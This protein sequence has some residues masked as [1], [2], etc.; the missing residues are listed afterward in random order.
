MIDSPSAIRTISPCRSAKCSGAI[1][2]P[3][4]RDHRRAHVVDRKRHH[5][6]RDPRVPLDEGGHHEQ[7]RR[8]AVRG[9]HYPQERAAGRGRCEQRWRRGRGGAR[10]RRG[11]RTRTRR[12]VSE[13]AGHRQGD[14]EHRP[15]G[16]EHD[17]PDAALIDVQRAGQPGIAAPR[18]PDRRQHEHP[19]K[20]SAPRRVIGEQAR[21]L[22]DREHEDQVEEQ[23]ERGDLMLAVK[24][25]VGRLHPG[26][27]SPA[28]PTCRRSWT[29]A[30]RSGTAD[31]R[32]R[33]GRRC[34]SRSSS[35]YMDTVGQGLLPAAHDDR[36]EKELE[37][38]DQPCR[39]RLGSEVG[40][41]HR[42]VAVG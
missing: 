4:P 12:V 18:P 28:R 26:H 40:P 42:E 29:F 1:R 21:D 3:R 33:C 6:D 32:S 14:A 41:A 27:P 39:E 15:H 13:R 9:R 11:T 8:R 17:Q 30:G 31:T 25:G 34:S 16:G 22:R 20:H 36:C 10:G 37:L 38:V 24:L 2:H 23:L 7:R 5:P 19:P 35:G